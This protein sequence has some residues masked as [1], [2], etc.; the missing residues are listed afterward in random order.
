MARTRDMFDTDD[1]V[2][3]TERFEQYKAALSTAIASPVLV[4]PGATPGTIEKAA[5]PAD[6]PGSSLRKA[7]ASGELEKSGVSAEVVESLRTQLAQA[8]AV[9]TSPSPGLQI[10]NPTNLYAYDLEQGAKILAPR[11]T[12]LRNRIARRKGVGTAHEFR[13]ITG[14]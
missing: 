3:I 5:A 2:Q 11:P 8:D 13:R 14:F 7:I 6:T 1:S 12:P 10:G 9:K 4:H